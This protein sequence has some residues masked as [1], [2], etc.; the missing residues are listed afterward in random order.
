ML[1]AEPRALSSGNQQHADLTRIERRAACGKCLRE[2]P[3]ILGRGQAKRTGRFGLRGKLLIIDSRF[4]LRAQ[5]LEKFQINFSKLRAQF[6]LLCCRQL[7]QVL[8]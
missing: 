3:R 2:V 4:D 6:L 8:H 1:K 5:S 7:T